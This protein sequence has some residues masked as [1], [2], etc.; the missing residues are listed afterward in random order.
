MQDSQGRLTQSSTQATERCQEGQGR[1]DHHLTVSSLFA[2]EEEVVEEEVVEE[3]GRGQR[4]RGNFLQ[5]K[6]TLWGY[7]L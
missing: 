6:G 3:E 7:E 4:E 2:V 5:R 1:K